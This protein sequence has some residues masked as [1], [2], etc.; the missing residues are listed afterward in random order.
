MTCML[1]PMQGQEKEW[2]LYLVSTGHDQWMRDS[3]CP[4]F[5]A[6]FVET[7]EKERRT[8]FEISHITAV[9]ASKT[10]QLSFTVVYTKQSLIAI[11][12][13]QWTCSKT[14]ISDSTLL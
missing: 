1:E 9:E 11:Q 7:Q 2:K 10:P 14:L 8:G 13:L 12:D 4:F 5:K 3:T 6:T